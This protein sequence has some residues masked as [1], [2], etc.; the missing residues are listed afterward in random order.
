MPTVAEMR[1]LERQGFR[2]D[3]RRQKKQSFGHICA[4]SGARGGVRELLGSQDTT[5]LGGQTR[6]LPQTDL[7]LERGR[8]HP[9]SVQPRGAARG[10][11]GRMLFSRWCRRPR[12]KLWYAAYPVLLPSSL[13]SLSAKRRALATLARHGSNTRREQPAPIPSH[14]DSHHVDARSIDSRDTHVHRWRRASAHEVISH[15]ILKEES[16]NPFNI[17]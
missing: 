8:Q 11:F 12:P 14:V 17:L 6:N 10:L 5:A 9:K 16:N 7:R 1:T 15:I 13:A 4:P 3:A 2:S